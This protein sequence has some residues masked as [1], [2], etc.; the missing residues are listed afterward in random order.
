[1]QEMTNLSGRL[2]FQVS[3]YYYLEMIKHS[4][5]RQCFCVAS[6]SDKIAFFF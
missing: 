4:L 6:F 1:V 3:L 2:S 5:Y